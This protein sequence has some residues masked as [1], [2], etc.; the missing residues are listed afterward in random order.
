MF[1]QGVGYERE[2]FGSQ[3]NFVRKDENVIAK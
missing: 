2:T 3:N 1:C